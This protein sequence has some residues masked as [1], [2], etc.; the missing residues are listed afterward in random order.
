MTEKSEESN[1]L[2]KKE[3]TSLSSTN[4]P[5]VTNEFIT[6]LQEAE[7]IADYI[8]T[9]PT[10]NKQFEVQI[11]DKD[12]KLLGTEIS[13]SDIISCILLGKEIGLQPMAAI[14]LGKKLNA[15]SYFSVLKGKEL[16]VDPI[17]AIQQISLIPTKN[18]DL[19]HTGTHIINKVLIDNGVKR[20]VLADFEPIFKY[21]DMK[22]NV[23]YDILTDDLFEYL[24]GVT[25]I[26]ELTNA[27]KEN[28]KI[29][30]KYLADRFTEMRFERPSKNIDIIKKLTLQ[31]CTDC[32]WYKGYHS[33]DK[34]A[35]GTPIYIDGNFNWNTM[36]RL[37]LYNRV[38]SQG[39]RDVCD[40]RLNGLYS[41]EEVA[42]FVPNIKIED[43]VAED[44]TPI[45]ET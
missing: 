37:M 9:S 33:I 8:A 15:K 26:V 30:V 13:K 6:R 36:T 28:K 7:K 25:P 35:D 44:V 19:Y 10:F 23:L 20:T 16:G 42:D 32:G 5:L 29:V 21:K 40:D 31:E 12:G 17:S 41:T 4:N 45:K 38:I 24:K 1:K 18:G 27:T 14:V 39:G 34:N 22:T 3:E 43:G 2:I 11:K